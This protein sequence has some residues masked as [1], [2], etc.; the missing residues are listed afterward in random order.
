MSS[1]YA[2]RFREA[3]VRT[4]AWHEVKLGLA[5]ETLRSQAEGL[6]LATLADIG[7]VLDSPALEHFDMTDIRVRCA[8]IHRSVFANQHYL[9]YPCVLTVGDVEVDGVPHYET[10]YAQLDDEMRGLHR[11]SDRPYP[12]H[13]WLTFPDMHIV[14]VT[15]LIYHF[16]DQIP[17]HFRWSDYITCSD[18]RHRSAIPVSLR[19]QPML[20]GEACVT[21]MVDTD[22]R[23]PGY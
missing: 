2:D 15:F 11:D 12:C 8:E 16:P 23:R 17:Q 20:V 18:P 4:R 6:A 9:R 22:V 1:S 5:F 7:R 3:E 10:T 21:A 19:Y 13:V 14:D